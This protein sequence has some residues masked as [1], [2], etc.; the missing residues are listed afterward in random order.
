M[1]QNSCPRST[2][3]TLT[4]KIK[5]LGVREQEFQLRKLRVLLKRAVDNWNELPAQ[6][7]RH[8]RS[9]GSDLENMPETP[10]GGNPEIESLASPGVVFADAAWHCR[11]RCP[12]I[13]LG[14][15]QSIPPWTICRRRCSETGGCRSLNSRRSDASLVYDQP[16]T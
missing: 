9:L 6:L 13:K 2:N 1:K 10:L 5:E 12:R 4:R 14:S 15:A 3:A 16:A 8:C 11:R 7:A